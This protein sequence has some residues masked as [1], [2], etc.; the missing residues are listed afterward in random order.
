MKRQ[1]L[2]PALA[3]FLLAPI[4]GELLSGSMPPAEFFNPINFTLAA[5][6]YGSGALLARE[7]AQRWGQGWP[8]ILVLGAAYGIIEEGLAVKSFFDPNWVDLG[9]LGEYGRWAGVNWVWSLQLTLYHAVFSIAIPILL[10]NLL[11]PAQ[12]GQSWISR[13]MFKVLSVVFSADVVFMYF[14]LTPY[15]PPWLPY[16]LA[17]LGVIGLGVVARRLPQPMFTANRVN[18]PRPFWF[19]LTGFLFTVA[20]FFLADG[21]PNMNIEPGLTLLL[22]ADLPIVA[23]WIV[24]QMSGHG[25]AWSSQHQLALAAG[26]LSFFILLAPLQELDTA[27][28]DNTTGMSLVGL[29]MAL[30]LVW[31]SWRV[32]QNKQ[33]KVSAYGGVS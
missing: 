13:R 29:A 11:F 32:R 2:S 6:L 1:F 14:A 33:Y 22:L 30:F 4:I 7:L 25:A 12:R 21:L 31:L 10:V 15:R 23:G 5:T 17:V 26:G 18:V 28:P 3:L 9:V 20:L 24:L 27:R 19:G 8:S 16:L